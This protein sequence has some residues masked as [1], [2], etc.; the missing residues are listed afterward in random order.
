MASGPKLAIDKTFRIQN[1][2]ALI[3][4]VWWEHGELKDL[5]QHPDRHPLIISYHCFNATVT[6][7]S[8]LD[9]II[10]EFQL[11]E[12]FARWVDYLKREDPGRVT[13]DLAKTDTKKRVIIQSWAR[14]CFPS[15]N[16]CFA[17]ANA[18]KHRSLSQD[19]GTLRSSQVLRRG[20]TF[21][22][23][24]GGRSDAFGIP[25][26]IWHQQQAWGLEECALPLLDVIEEAA[27][28]LET[29]LDIASKVLPDAESSSA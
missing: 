9:W 16:V 5:L 14:T 17:I 3:L 7:W 10:D 20:I 28:S 21:V 1:S 11:V 24:N 8:A 22:D 25:L 4:K 23:R 2:E 13:P 26:V 12:L 19:T 15:L 18:S 27:E 29:I 6:A